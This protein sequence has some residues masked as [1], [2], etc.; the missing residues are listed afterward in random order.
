MTI[1]GIGPV[2]AT[3]L[4]ASV[5][6]PHQ[7]RSRRQFAARLGLTPLQKSCAVQSTILRKIEPDLVDLLARKFTRVATA[8]KTARVIWAIMAHARTYRA[9]PLTGIGR[10]ANGA[11]IRNTTRRA[12][13]ISNAYQICLPDG[14]RVA[15]RSCC[16]WEISIIAVISFPRYVFH[17]S[18]R[19]QCKRN[20]ST[21]PSALQW[22]QP[23]DNLGGW[24]PSKA[25]R[26]GRYQSQVH[27]GR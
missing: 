16:W 17:D 4:A 8:N 21:C 27:Y 22:W 9:S 3:A 23:A 15:R 6:D 1:P 26:E 14:G 18:E 19:T 5:T 11:S 25:A 20:S 24:P 7:F 12:T 2:G 13:A 10:V